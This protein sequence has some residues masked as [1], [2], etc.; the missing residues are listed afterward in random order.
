M[1]ACARHF[2]KGKGA[3]AFSPWERAPLW[4]VCK[5]LL[6]HCKGNKASIGGNCTPYLREVSYFL[7]IISPDF[8]N[9]NLF[10]ITL[11]VSE[12]P[13]VRSRHLCW[14]PCAAIVIMN[15]DSCGTKKGFRLFSIISLGFTLALE[16]ETVFEIVAMVIARAA[17]VNSETARKKI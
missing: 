11:S 10:K 9:G 6:K 1:Q 5:F 16:G 14:V 8:E 12:P 13:V 15:T 3:K 2:W 17:R 7:V 4:G